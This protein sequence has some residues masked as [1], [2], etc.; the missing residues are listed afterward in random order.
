MTYRYRTPESACLSCGK[1]LDA[2]GLLDG[3]PI[4]PPGDGDTTLCIGCGAVMK[5][6]P[7]GRL[8]GMTDA[9]MH[10]I[11]GDAEYMNFLARIV[12]EIHFVRMMKN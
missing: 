5:Y 1:R 4:E 11:T 8:R 10:E 7:D 12:R 3:Q 2:A 6:G 9:E